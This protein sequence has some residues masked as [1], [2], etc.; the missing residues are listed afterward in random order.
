MSMLNFFR[1]F[2]CFPL[3][4]L[5]GLANSSNLIS[6][7]CFLALVKR[8]LVCKILPEVLVIASELNNSGLQVLVLIAR[9][10]QLPSHILAALDL[11]PQVSFDFLVVPD[12]HVRF[13]L[14]NLSLNQSFFL[15]SDRSDLVLVVVGQLLIAGF[16]VLDLS[17]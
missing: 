3:Q 1:E 14:E 7:S 11:V 13:V 4:L 15:G 10:L 17:N 12:H 5:I 9:M 2:K 16:Q 6:K 8:L